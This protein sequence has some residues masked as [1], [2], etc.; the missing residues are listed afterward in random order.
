MSAQTHEILVDADKHPELTPRDDVVVVLAGVFAVRVVA[1]SS[2]ASP[3]AARTPAR[4][5][6]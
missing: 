3:T 6:P 2:A 4:A 1:R 5:A